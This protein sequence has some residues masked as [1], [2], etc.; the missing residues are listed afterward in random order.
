[1]MTMK[2]I[3]KGI[4]A[5]FLCICMMLVS[6]PAFAVALEGTGSSADP[7]R[8]G[9]AVQLHEFAWRVNNNGGNK[10]TN[11]C[12]VLTDD[13]DYREDY[14]NWYA[15]GSKENPYVGIFDGAGK[16][17]S[18]LKLDDANGFNA[19]I[20]V[21]GSGGEVRNLKVEASF[22]G[23]GISGGI[24][25]RSF[26][27]IS[28]CEFDGSIS[29]HSGITST[30]NFMGGIVGDNSGTVIECRSKGS[31][32]GQNYTG[33]IV[34]R[35][36]GTVSI[37]SSS[38]EVTGALY[39][40]GIA[41]SNESDILDC[42]NTGS[43]SG[44]NHV[45]GVV[46]DN[47]GEIS[48]CH[49]ASQV[50]ASNPGGLVGSNRE[51]A[52]V[53]NSYSHTE[54]PTGNSIA[55]DAGSRENVGK[56]GAAGFKNGTVLGILKGER[57]NVIW[58]QG[59]EYPVF[60]QKVASVQVSITNPVQGAVPQSS[61][62]PGTGYTAEISWS[63]A[64]TDGKFGFNTVY[65]ATVTLTPD[66][67]HAFADPTTIP[68]GFSKNL[69]ADGT[70][71]LTK[72]FAKTRLPNLT[73]LKT[74][75]D[76]TLSVYCKDAAE[77][78]A[79]LPTQMI[80][81]T[82][83]GDLTLDV[84]WICGSYD[85]EVGKINTFAWAVKQSAWDAVKDSYNQNAVPLNG[86]VNLTNAQAVPIM[87]T[88]VA[89]AQ[90]LVYDGTAK[91]GYT[92]TPTS[93]EYAGPFTITYTGT[94][95]DESSYGPTADAPSNAGEYTVTI[96]V[97][98]TGTAYSG[99]TQVSF[100][101][102]K[103]TQTGEPVFTPIYRD[104]KTLADAGLTAEG[105]TFSVAGTVAWDDPLTTVVQKGKAY[106]WTFTPTDSGNY[107]AIRGSA[108]IY[109]MGDAPAIT[110]PM[111]IQMISADPGSTITMTVVAQGT[112]EL[113]YQWFV[114]HDGGLTFKAISGAT[115][116]TYTTA[117]LTTGSH[118]YRYYCLVTNLY[119]ETVSPFFVLSVVN[120]AALPQTGDTENPVLWTMLMLSAAVLMFA[121]R[122]RAA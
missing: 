18:G 31:V 71:T 35:N 92:G 86:T 109:P 21:L 70:M 43:I 3:G 34:G 79:L 15:I 23:N 60:K 122:R 47:M 5:L 68:E 44:Q 101:I 52:S 119:G 94:K 75:L 87:I 16:T 1:M 111:E 114:S 93:T 49:N 83:T 14:D 120:P 25:G 66:S 110:D 63:P 89:A 30:V 90:D 72:T 33:G 48:F 113:T 95:A 32:N 11:A 100:S 116:P 65:T 58:T 50:N 8:I 62:A 85:P 19:F 91:Q 73:K 104:G 115:Q 10:Q 84:A 7:Y 78:I 98:A 77:A 56:L 106:A 37:C 51:R 40:G 105:G 55:S 36:Q 29:I 20:R 88:G 64:V 54:Y 102:A 118:G 4:S 28:N 82:E 17:I 80:F 96:A 45:G 2:A 103:A 112:S 13:I 99:Q 42:Y 39:V 61:V 27:T 59:T 24:A 22:G 53:K 97:P 9:T 107:E 74:E 121:R 69:N 12:A 26:G 46:G 117:A 41:G 76:N 67:N 57:E 6:L 38:A 81:E 108:V